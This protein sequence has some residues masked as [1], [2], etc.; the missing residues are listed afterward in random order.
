M[1]EELLDLIAEDGGHLRQAMRSEVDASLRRWDSQPI[2]S[3]RKSSNANEPKPQPTRTNSPTSGLDQEPEE[4]M[5]SENRLTKNSNGSFAES[6]K[7]LQSAAKGHFSKFAKPDVK[8]SSL[9][10]A[11]TSEAFAEEYTLIDK[12][13]LRLLSLQ[14]PPRSGFLASIVLGRVFEVSVCTII[15]LNC[16]FL[17]YA[18]DVEISTPG[19]ARPELLACDWAFQ[20]AY[21]FEL[22]CRIGVHGRWTFFNKDAKQN[23]FDAILVFGG[24]AS[25]L[26]VNALNPGVMKALRW[27]KFGKSIRA[28][29]LMVQ[30][31]HLRAFVVCLQG[32]FASLLWSMVMLFSV[33]LLFSLFFM[34]IITEHIVD[35]GEI[36][37]GGSFDEFFGSVGTS[38]LT[39]YMA[40]TGG[41]DWKVAYDVIRSTGPVGSFVFLGFVAFVQFALI[42]IITGIFVEAA[43]QTLSPNAETL[44]LENA[45][46][47]KDNAKELE[48]LC[49]S[50]DADFSGKLTREQFEDGL[51]RGRIPMLLTL[52]GLHRHHVLEFFNTMA[53]IQDQDGQVDIHAFVTGCMHMKGTATN[54]DLQMLHL[55][56]RSSREQH[57]EQ[58]DKIQALLSDR[59]ENLPPSTP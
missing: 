2:R 58:M 18:T 22:I 17:I 46:K 23:T 42:N 9:Y 14:E 3:V 43:M 44:A 7:D 5:P 31:R 10:S 39:L 25:L 48:S 19:V 54:Y 36:L 24:L 32:S 29:K 34:Q 1:R 38:V 40:S 45:R 35:T 8:H 30:L 15:L 51:R 27:L 6:Q 21:T 55:E 26:G 56:F 59:L 41:D 37:E 20:A 16:L 47:E 12:W 53:M 33:Y 4:G 11:R 57:H 52:L 13:L 49:R 50:V 28:I